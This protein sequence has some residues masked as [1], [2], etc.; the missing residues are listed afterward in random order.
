[1]EQGSAPP[2]PRVRTRTLSPRAAPRGT[3]DRHSPCLPGADPTPPLP[4]PPSSAGKEHLG[5]L[6]S[7]PRARM[8][9]TAPRALAAPAPETPPP[10]REPRRSPGSARATPLAPLGDAGSPRPPS[11]EPSAA[12]VKPPRRSRDSPQYHQL[13][14]FH[15][16][17][18]GG[19]VLLLARGKHGAP[20]GRRRRLLR[21][22]PRGVR[23][24]AT[25]P[26]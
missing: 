26:S 19:A 14:V 7:T 2:S 18:I 13:P 1:M 16:L 4:R 10:P 21:R 17:L 3:R 20:I 15:R 12:A 9:S 5:G 22:D 8:G 23:A 25:I 11:P 6:C 24:S